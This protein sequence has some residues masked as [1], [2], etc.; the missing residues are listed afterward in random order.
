MESAKSCSCEEN[1]I[2]NELSADTSLKERPLVTF[3]LFAFNQEKYI[4]EAV[5]GAFSQTY[6]PLEIILS[7]D[8][9]SDCTFNIMREIVATYSGKHNVILSSNEIN[10]GL[11]EHVNKVLNVSKGDLVVLAAGDDVSVPERVSKIVKYWNSTKFSLIHSDVYKMH[12]NGDLIGVEK[13]PMVIN[14]YSLQ[15]LALSLSLYI[16]AS[17]AI[18]KKI[19]EKYGRIKYSRSYEDLVYG[20]RAILENSIG[21]ISEP[22]VFYRKNTGIISRNRLND[23][24]KE[25]RLNCLLNIADN[26]RQRLDDTLKCDRED[27]QYLVSILKKNL[28]SI[29]IKIMLY[30]NQGA[31]LRCFFGKR[32]LM[33]LKAVY[34]ETKYLL[35]DWKV[36]I[37]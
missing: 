19:I 15:E 24:Y 18:E 29:R 3:A 25:W 16:G 5:E 7:D 34:S 11:I 20:Y 28:E 4:R 10:L 27:S 33:G 9:S 26:Y 32:I 2:K 37:T 14:N 8:C 12:V 30:D 21:Y 17:G 35:K 13:P 36:M 1:D 31:F 23:N 22:L 6:E